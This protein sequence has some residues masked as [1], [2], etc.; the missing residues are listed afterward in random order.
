MSTIFDIATL[1]G[2]TER[3]VVHNGDRKAVTLRREYP[4][5]VED[6]WSAWTD[7]ERA[8]R[9]L[10]EIRGE[11]RP[12]ST[13]ELCM[14]PPDSDIAT[15][16]ILL[17]EPP[18]RLLV[19][20]EWPDEGDSYVDLRIEPLGGSRCALT[21]EHV[22]LVDDTT[23]SYGTGWEDFLIRAG[24]MLD[25]REPGSVPWEAIGPAIKPLWTASVEACTTDE[26]W[27]VVSDMGDS[28]ALRA[29][30]WFPH[31]LDTVWET[32]TA[33]ASLDAW[34]GQFSGEP[35]QGQ[36]FTVT[37]D[38]GS[39]SG[40]VQEC[41]RP[42]HLAVT[43]TWSHQD[44]E[45]LVTVDL[46]SERDGTCVEIEQSGVVGPALGYAAGW[47]AYLSAAARHLAGRARSEAAWQADWQMAQ[48][49][50]TRQPTPG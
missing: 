38:G 23:I 44:F 42:S 15:L 20:W 9:W 41:V 33:P 17:C 1:V 3:V 14:S 2:L 35:V 48:A 10:G 25:G 22:A 31:P 4:F 16:T 50:I 13:I 21:L 47:S 5:P 34:F 32:L 12:G 30:R 8:A 6:V 28:A 11:A 43:W 26:R 40:L 49:M 29:V 37:F 46:T 27:P 7:P 19:K 36:R 18:S 39:A 45:T 24:L